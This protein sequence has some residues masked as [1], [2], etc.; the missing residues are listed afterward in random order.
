[1]KKI[2]SIIVL[3]MAATSMQAQTGSWTI[4]L[5]NKLLLATAKEDEVKNVKKIT[6]A[7]WKKNGKLEIYFTE[8]DPD[9]WYRAFRFCDEADNELLVTDSSSAVKIPISKLRAVFKGKKKIVIYTTIS[10]R[11]SN[12]AVR[13]RRVHLCTLRL[14]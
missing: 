12:L 6:A 2:I 5:N 13:I 4:K 14:Q 11:D 3:L 1:M 10:P 8:T 9:T 7:E